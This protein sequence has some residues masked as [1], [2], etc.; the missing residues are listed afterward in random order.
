VKC[1][2]TCGF[3]FALLQSIFLSMGLLLISCSDDAGDGSWKPW[4]KQSYSTKLSATENPIYEGGKWINGHSIGL[5]WGDVQTAAG[6]AIGTNVS[7]APPYDDSTAVLAGEWGS[8]QMAQ[9]TV[10]TVNQTR[11]IAEEVELRL[12]TT[13]TPHRI[14]G[15][16]FDYRVTSDG[17]QY[18][19]IVRWEGKLNKCTYLT[20]DPCTIC[21]R[22]LHNGDTIKATA[23][24]DTLALYIN[25]RKYVELKDTKFLGGSPGIGF[26]NWGGKVADN[27]NYGFTDFTASDLP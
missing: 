24:G 23:I 11:A 26:W 4:K 9:A 18:L 17:A 7:A 12:R 3:R 15:C 20:H 25:D 5:D 8:N 19:G 2:R 10:Y 13:I 22:G 6:L 14:T 16:E 27:K 1:S 21:G